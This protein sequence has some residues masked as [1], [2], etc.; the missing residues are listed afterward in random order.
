MSSGFSA[1]ITATTSE[2]EN[3]TNERGGKN[4]TTKL[5]GKLLSLYKEKCGWVS[6]R[7]F[8]LQV[9]YDEGKLDDGD[10]LVGG[11]EGFG[12]E[13]G[14]NVRMRLAATSKNSITSETASSDET[15]PLLSLSLKSQLNERFVCGR[16]FSN[17]SSVDTAEP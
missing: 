13:S 1:K 5:I 11:T 14:A 2:N 4:Q 6:L 17:S 10:W 7:L 8:N 16:K 15:T 12:A 9:V 3:R